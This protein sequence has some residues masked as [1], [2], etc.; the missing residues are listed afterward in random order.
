MRRPCGNARVGGGARGCS[1][2]ACNSC[3]RSMRRHSKYGDGRAAIHEWLVQR[4]Q[5]PEAQQQ[6][7][8]GQRLRCGTAMGGACSRRAIDKQVPLLVKGLQ[9]GSHT[10][11]TRCTCS[12]SLQVRGSEWGVCA[13]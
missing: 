2:N 12:S 1:Y 8:E 10:A 9:G 3:T 4:E 11:R 5:D 7:C 13:S 6:A